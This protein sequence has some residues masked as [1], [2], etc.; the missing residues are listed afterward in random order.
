MNPRAATNDELLLRRL[1]ENDDESAAAAL[2]LLLY[3]QSPEL[4]YWLREDYARD[5]KVRARIDSLAKN[6][7]LPPVARF[8]ELTED[9]DSWRE[10]QRRLKRQMPGR[11]YG[12][13]TWNEVVRLAHHYQA[14]TLDLG[15]FLL[16]RNWRATGHA[17]PFL[18]WAGLAW[19]EAVLPSG[20]RRLL[21]HLHAALAFVKRYENKTTR[22]A[23][24]GYADW[25][26]L[27][28]V[29]YILRNPR[30]AYRT[31]EVRAHL[32][33]LGLCI[34]ALDFR[35]FCT[36]HGICRDMR[37]GRPRKRT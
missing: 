34:S 11:I 25:W 15:T 12:G 29:I 31:R 24:V 13:L 18:L 3:R 14:G 32:A 5:A 30:P 23:A 1:T 4:Q 22:R 16:V 28:T 10:E 7:T 35:R 17:S 2:F 36:R 27:Q 33:G 6:T 9:N 21:K 26:K 19:L 37:A 8:A 20:R